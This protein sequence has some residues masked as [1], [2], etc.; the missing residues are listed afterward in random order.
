MGGWCGFRRVGK[1]SNK[2]RTLGLVGH[3]CLARA[4]AKYGLIRGRQEVLFSLV[5]NILAIACLLSILK[6][7]HDLLKSYPYP[8]ESLLPFVVPSLDGLQ[9]W[10]GPSN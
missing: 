1:R 2:D 8:L 9:N 6:I 10:G 5:L 4:V 3:D 7:A